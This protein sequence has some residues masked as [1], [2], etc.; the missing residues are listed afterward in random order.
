MKSRPLLIEAL[1]TVL[2]L[3]GAILLGLTLFNRYR[4]L[5]RRAEVPQNLK[6]IVEGA[7]TFS[8]RAALRRKAGHT[9]AWFPESSAVTPS[10]RCCNEGRSTP[11]VP[12]G[13]TA[14]G[15]SH[16]E[17]RSDTWKALH[18]ELKD[19]HLFRYEFVKRPQGEKP[20]FFAQAYGDLDCDGHESLYR[21]S[22]HIEGD[23][24]R[25]GL[26]LETVRDE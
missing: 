21:R 23:H 8:D 3:G 13:R 17:W 18:F 20:G 10:I 4:T 7:V 6:M 15:Y 24:V 19:P 14:T 11:C 9:A 1:L 16:R 26:E 5:A 25:P 12:S 22:G 2:I